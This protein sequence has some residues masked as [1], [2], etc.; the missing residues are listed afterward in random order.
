M[1]VRSSSERLYL[2]VCSFAEVAMLGIAAYA[3][4]PSSFGRLVCA[5]LAAVALAATMHRV[6]ARRA[7]QD[8]D[9]PFQSAAAA[10]AA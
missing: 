7:E 5:S 3:A 4:D 1:N 9:G 6:W 8:M 10:A 2:C